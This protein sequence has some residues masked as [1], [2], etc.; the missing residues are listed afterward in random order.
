MEQ[1]RTANDGIDDELLAR[2][3]RAINETRDLI[4]TANRIRQRIEAIRQA[5]AERAFAARTF[6]RLHGTG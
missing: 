3:A 1:R 5:A 4:E 2:A 6:A